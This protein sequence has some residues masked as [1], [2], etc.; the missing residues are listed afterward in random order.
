MKLFVINEVL[1]VYV[2][3]N[4]GDNNFFIL[5][6]KFFLV[7]WWIS[8]GFYFFKGLCDSNSDELVFEI[9]VV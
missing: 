1:I 2:I 9:S 3:G 5:V 8:F 6:C 7:V 4:N